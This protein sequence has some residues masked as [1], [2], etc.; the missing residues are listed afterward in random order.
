MA[1]TINEI[2]REMVAAKEA[3][4]T[5]AQ[6][7]SNSATALW[8]LLFYVV[9][10]AHW[11]IESLFDLHGSEVDERI[12]AQRPHTLGWYR[13]TA[14]DFQFGKE[15][16]PDLTEYDNS[17][18]TAD[19]IDEQR[20]VRKCAVNPADM[21]RPTLIVKVAK[22]DG[23]L[24]GEELI[25]FTAY[26]DAKADAGVNIETISKDPDR[27]VLLMVIRYDAMAMDSDG[28]RLIDGRRPVED[29]AIEY[30]ASLPFNGVFYP[31]KL[32]QELMRQPGIRVATIRLAQAAMAEQV[33]VDITDKYLPYSGALTIDVAN[34]LHVTYERF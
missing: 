22:A 5:L 4:P 7:S 17:G 14:L 18:L 8:R 23:K 12:R 9:A 32:E 13:Q 3:E 29:V 21:D 16:M 25:A 10:S 15:F 31:S 30:L 26:M 2:F 34:D 28:N 19:E 33:P 24:T 20:I 11:L 27:L 6:L 1:R